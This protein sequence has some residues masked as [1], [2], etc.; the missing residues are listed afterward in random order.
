MIPDEPADKPAD[1]TRDATAPTEELVLEA[2]ASPGQ[3]HGMGQTAELTGTI[4]IITDTLPSDATTPRLPPKPEGDLSLEQYAWV[5]AQEL[6]GA[7]GLAAAL[8]ATA[9]TP[10][11][12][13][14]WKLHWEARMLHHPN[15]RERWF[16]LVAKLR[17]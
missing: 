9:L 14:A 2:Q 10:E 15:E 16:T 4:P 8:A 5:Y 17:S 11:R 7:E 1:E 6:G 3:G 12:Y 13:R